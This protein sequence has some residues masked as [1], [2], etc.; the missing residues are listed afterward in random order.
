VLPAEAVHARA[1]GI[2][3]RGAAVKRNHLGEICYCVGKIL[4]RSIHGA[5]VREGRGHSRIQLNRPIEILKGAV[6]I[7]QRDV[8]YAATCVGDGEILGVDAP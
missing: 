4:P 6:V 5:P 3:R 7:Q 8:R 1:V 2:R